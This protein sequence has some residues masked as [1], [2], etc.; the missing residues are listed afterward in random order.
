[1]STEEITG[2]DPTN[3]VPVQHIHGTADATVPYDGTA[4]PSLSLVPQTIDK[5][6]ITNGWNGDSTIT[7]IPDTKADGITIEKIVYNA[8]TPLELWKMNGADHIYL[9]PSINDTAGVFVSWYWFNQFTH[10]NPSTASVTEKEII[11][12]KIEFYPNP[13]TDKLFIKK[14]QTLK[15]VRIYNVNGQAVLNESVTDEFLDINQIISGIYIIEFI[16]LDGTI[17][18]DK[19]IIE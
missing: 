13:A 18:Q 9:F 1:M 17:I 5:L 16:T 2:Y 15:S 12:N 4:L 7:N 8:T 19:L 6:K 14:F 11:Q 3:P 10:P